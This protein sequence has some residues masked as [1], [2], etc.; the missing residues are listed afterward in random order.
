MMILKM[1]RSVT[2]GLRTVRHVTIREGHV[3]LIGQDISTSLQMF[4]FL[5]S[6]SCLVASFNATTLV[7]YLS[8][9][10]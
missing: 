8:P 2:G 3:L 9:R 1:A 7:D 10:N 6:L 5:S 4:S